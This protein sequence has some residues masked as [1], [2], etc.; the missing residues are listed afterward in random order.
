M[1]A[2]K[3]IGPAEHSNPAERRRHQ[4]VPIICELQAVRLD[5]EG[6]GVM[7]TLQGVDISR[8]GLGART[9]RMYYP[10]QRMLVA[11]PRTEHGGR[12]NLYATVV[13]SR[14]N[15]DAYEV[16]LQFDTSSVDSWCGVSTHAVAA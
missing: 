15:S 1:I 9:Q 16:G 13:R 10:G 3:T 12:R 4:R 11:M 5:P 6:T 8:S 14:R 7:D 2:A